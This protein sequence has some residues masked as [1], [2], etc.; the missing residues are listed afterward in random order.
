V[1]TNATRGIF[2]RGERD[3]DI[4]TPWT[5][6]AQRCTQVQPLFGGGKDASLYCIGGGNY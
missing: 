2:D 3:G 1:K 4:G 5:I 6:L